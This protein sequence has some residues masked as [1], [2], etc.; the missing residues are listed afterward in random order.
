MLQTKD[1]DNPFAGVWLYQGESIYGGEDGFDLELNIEGTVVTGTFSSVLNR[2]NP[3]VRIDTGTI[4]G[5][6]NKA[7]NSISGNWEGDRYDAGTVT[8][9]LDPKTNALIWNSTLRANGEN[10]VPGDYSIPQ[11]MRLVRFKPE[12][13]EN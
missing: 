5:V 11:S 4:T 1:S 13:N 9:R 8:M 6:Y 7:K 3:A 2:I 12:G 10:F